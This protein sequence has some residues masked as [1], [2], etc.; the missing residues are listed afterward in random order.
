MLWRGNYARNYD[1]I[2]FAPLLFIAWKEFLQFCWHTSA[3]NF[4]N[5]STNTIFMH[6]TN[7]R[8]SLSLNYLNLCVLPSKEEGPVS[9]LPSWIFN[10]GDVVSSHTHSGGS[11]SS[12]GDGKG[13]II[14]VGPLPRIVCGNPAKKLMLLLSQNVR[15]RSTWTY[16]SYYTS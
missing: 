2:I 4:I 11:G 7:S 12:V 14:A 8:Q 15:R 16:K 6:L 3:D 10:I 1:S 9:Y 13:S 5:I